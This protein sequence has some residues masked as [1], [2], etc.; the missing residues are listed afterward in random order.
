MLNILCLLHVYLLHV[1]AR[2]RTGIRKTTVDFLRANVPELWN[3]ETS[4][5]ITP[6]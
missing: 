6:I 2:W 5:S 3:P 4:V 1:K